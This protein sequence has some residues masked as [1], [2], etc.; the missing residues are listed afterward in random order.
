[1]TLEQLRI[2]EAVA[3]REHVTRAAEEL[4]LTQSAVSA[5]IAALEERHSVALFSRVGRRVELWTRDACF[6]T[7]H[8]P[9]W[10]APGRRSSPCRRSPASGAALSQFMRA[11]PSRAIGCRRGWLAFAG[12]TLASR[13][14]SSPA[15]RP[16]WQGPFKTAPP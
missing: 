10:H 7:R 8:A 2:F 14:I 5:A 13:S 4:N 15:T 11:R 16:K 3:E 6:S 1:M 9:C 12:L